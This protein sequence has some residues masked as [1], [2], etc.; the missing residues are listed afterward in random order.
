MENNV[1]NVNKKPNVFPKST[2][3]QQQQQPKELSEYEKAAKQMKENTERDLKA[4][5][6]RL[7]KE[8]EAGLLQQ[9]K[10]NPNYQEQQQEYQPQPQNYIPNEV[11]T[12]TVQKNTPSKPPLGYIQI[13]DN[14]ENEPWDLLPIPTGCKIYNKDLRNKNGGKIRVAYLSFADEDIL[15][16]NNLVINGN[17]VDVLLKRKILDDIDPS[18]MHESDRLAITLW[19]R[20]TSYGHLYTINVVNPT[21]NQPI[22]NPKTNLPYSHDID[23]SALKIKDLEVEPDDDGYFDFKLPICEKEI[24]FKLLVQRDEDELEAIH[25]YEQDELKLEVLHDNTHRLLKQIVCVDGNYDPL[26][27]QKTILL[28]NAGDS[29]KLKEYIKEITPYVD[30]SVDVNIPQSDGGTLSFK[31]FLS[32]EPRFWWP[33]WKD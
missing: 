21:N 19:L 33:L 17:F 26:Y 27:I 29:L 10:Y 22:I 24:K 3:N 7:A 32:W 6:E 23:L 14:R 20:S 9:Q 28:L 31:S 4:R 5:Q 25:N 11:V 2:G 8:K 18:E 30:L 15:T 1:N 16:S 13:E 12:P